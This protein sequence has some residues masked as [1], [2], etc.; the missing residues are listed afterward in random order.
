MGKMGSLDCIAVNL[1]A[2]GIGV[3]VSSGGEQAWG[4]LKQK[5]L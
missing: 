2:E 1:E 5:H 3:E 4:S